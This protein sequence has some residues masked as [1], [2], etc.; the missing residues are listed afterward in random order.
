MNFEIEEIKN[1]VQV[2]SYMKK[3]VHNVNV[4]LMGSKFWNAARDVLKLDQSRDFV[5]LAVVWT[6]RIPTSHCLYFGSMLDALQMR[7]ALDAV[8]GKGGLTWEQVVEL[9][10][11]GRKWDR[12]V[13]LW[14]TKEKQ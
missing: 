11:D 4:V 1:A 3:N 14:Q 9:L 5:G 6:D 2:C 7:N 13:Q 8:M 12:E 10:K